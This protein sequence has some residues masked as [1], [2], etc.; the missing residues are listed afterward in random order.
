MF[1]I[2]A[3]SEYCDSSLV[4]YVGVQLKYEAQ[5]SVSYMDTR[6]AFQALFMTPVNFINRFDQSFRLVWSLYK[7]SFLLDMYAVSVCKNRLSNETAMS[8]YSILCSVQHY[9]SFY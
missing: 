3:L 2:F 1:N 7:L 5:Q 6:G 9:K 4:F 8:T